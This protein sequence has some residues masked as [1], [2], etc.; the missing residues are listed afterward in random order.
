MAKRA[1]AYPQVDPGAAA[2][3]DAP[4]A[5]VPRRARVGDALR[6][7]RRR[8]AAAVSADGRAFILRDDLARAARL[9]LDELPAAMLTR[10]VPVVESRTSEIAVRQHLA[11][12]APVVI[13]RD[14]RRGALGSIGATV[15][16]AVTSLSARFPERLGAFAR[17]A[18]LALGPVAREQKAAAYLV[19][20][21]VR[22]A[23]RT[24]GPLAARDLDVVVEGDGLA[25]ARALATAVGVGMSGLTEHAR[26][27]TASLASPPHGR[28]DI[29]TAR[30]ERYETPGALPRVIPASIGEDLGRRDFT[31]NAMAVELAS[32]G[33]GIL[34]PFGGRAALAR[35]R[36][37]VLHPLSFVEDPTR[38]FRAARYAAR[39]GF[40]L[41]AWTMRAVGLA[42]RL[43][44]YAA[45]SGQRLSGELAL[46]AADQRPDVALRQL[47]T[48]GVYRLLA[49]DYRFTNAVAERAR[50]LPAALAWGRAHGVAPSAIE[51]AAVVVLRGQPSTVIRSA[52]DRLV[53]T[54]EPRARIERALTRRVRPAPAGTRASDRARPWWGL[55]DLEI[56]TTWLA[57]GAARRDVEW[58]M[59]TA[60][61][62]RPA[63]GGD[64]I[65]AAGVA[66]GPRV[67]EAL[68]ALRDARLDRRVT[69]RDSEVLFMQDFV[70]PKEG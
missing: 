27:L 39:L 4:V 30:S 26:F 5:S 56:L 19:G 2:L 55:S 69:D 54:G 61:T 38:L 22:D 13:V 10:P 58:F 59:E 32:G 57:G 48:A 45:L 21:V 23:L 9:G 60:R 8:Q 42:L 12:G 16:T 1:H 35:R 36:I 46:I 37:T 17:E 25:V 53:I 18:L 63:L 51:A 43:A 14:G 33:Y 64:D 11:A 34:D 44:P 47:G 28:V 20:G 40:T 24:P 52:L 41:D 66:P 68:R 15:A 65:V 49:A 50:R 70:S 3:V 7:A 31:I 62:A 29:A 6:L 67:A